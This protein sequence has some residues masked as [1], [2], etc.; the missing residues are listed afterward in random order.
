[1]NVGNGL[2]CFSRVWAEES[3]P[4]I[5]KEERGVMLLKSGSSF[6]T[7]LFSTSPYWRGF[8]PKAV[9]R[10]RGDHLF[11]LGYYRA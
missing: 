7:P 2:G 3:L 5:R 4:P 8:S 1:M 11:E 10:P 6:Q 9:Q